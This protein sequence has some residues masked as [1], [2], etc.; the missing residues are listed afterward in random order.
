MRETVATNAK[1]ELQKAV[2]EALDT[3]LSQNKLATRMN[4]SAA[5]LINVKTGNWENVSDA[6][7][8]KLRAY[9]RLDSWGIR[10]THNFVA[11]TK[12]CDDAKMNNRMLAV[13]G[14]TGAGKTTAL[15]HYSQRNTATYYVLN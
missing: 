1:L 6:M 15:R 13:A 10:K 3:G 14:Y 5:T 4:V 9:F 12:L 7:V 8:R 11:I 2:K